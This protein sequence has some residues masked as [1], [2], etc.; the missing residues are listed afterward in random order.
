MPTA[1]QETVLDA[2][3]LSDTASA[4]ITAAAKASR[5]IQLLGDMGA[6]PNPGQTFDLG[7]TPLTLAD[8]D[9]VGGGARPGPGMVGAPQ[10]HTLLR[11][12]VTLILATHLSEVGI[13]NPGTGPGLLVTG[14]ACSTEAVVVGAG[15]GNGIEYRGFG[16]DSVTAVRT[17]A[18]LNAGDGVVIGPDPVDGTVPNSLVLQLSSR[19]N[20]GRQ[21]LV[22]CGTLPAD[23]S[24]KNLDVTGQFHAPAPTLPLVDLAGPVASSFHHLYL[25]T[26]TPATVTPMLQT[27]VTLGRACRGLDFTALRIHGG[28]NGKTPLIV[29]DGIYDS[30]IPFPTLDGMKAPTEAVPWILF[31]ANTGNNLV[32]IGHQAGSG[33]APSTKAILTDLGAGNDVRVT[34]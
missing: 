3:N 20:K 5:R 13:T 26:S 6:S 1:A 14:G 9:V 11:G 31:T 23:R 30:V 22:D 10:L 2:L 28:Y 8:V 17:V 27:R 32:R 24:G 4:V 29:F 7:S 12:S 25:E 16:D 15:G 21:L 18:M 34:L 19:G 33:A